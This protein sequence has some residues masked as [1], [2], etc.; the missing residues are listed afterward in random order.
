[1]IPITGK[2][3]IA[4]LLGSPVSHSI[5]PLMHNYS[6]QSLGIDCAYLC[7]DVGEDQLK[8]AVQGL[9]TLN[10]LG[11][12]LTMPNKNKIL[13]FLD[14][15]SPAARFIGAVNTVENRDGKL[16][17]HNTDGVG[18]MRSVR[19]EGISIKGKTM[20]LMGIGGAA[21]AI[22]AQAALDGLDTIHV[23]ARSSSRHLPRIQKLAAALQAET[24]CGILLHDNENLKEL[25]QCLSESALFVNATSVGMAPDTDACIL[26]DIS[27]L[28]KDTAVADIIYNPWETRL[29]S[30]ARSAGK[31]A[32]NGY[33]MLLYQGAEAFRIW[34][35]QEMPVEEVRRYL[36]KQ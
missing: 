35:G 1:M 4:G 13:E 32:F 22:C 9:L 31:K 18:F 23:F 25:K 28:G 10:V 29:L 33:S 34:T 3:R 7:F 19:E 15:L 8:E 20:T 6:F 11:F 27:W 30:Q 24:A 17:G 2:T 21:T 36:A 16:I 14:E 12:N 5:S 26:P